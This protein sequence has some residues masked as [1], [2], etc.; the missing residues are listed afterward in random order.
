MIKRLTSKRVKI[1]HSPPTKLDA[2]F[3]M[4]FGVLLAWS[5]TT[6]LVSTTVFAQN[7]G[8]LFF[9]V[10]LS[11]SLLCLI[12][13]HKSFALMGLAPLLVAL[14]FF[15]SGFL[16]TADET[17]F[18]NGFTANIMGAAYFLAGTG[19]LTAAYESIILWATSLL[20]SLFV[21]LFTYR[22]FHFFTLF[23]ISS[24]I[25]GSLLSA[26]VFRFPFSFQLFAFLM[27]VFFLKYLYQQNLKKFAR[28]TTPA[29]KYL[30][31]VPVVIATLFLS[32]LFPTPEPG[33]LDS[34]FQT[35]IVQPFDLVNDFFRGSVMEG[36]FSLQQVGFS[37]TTST[38]GGDV[39]L[40]D[41]LFM[42]IR[43]DAPLPI[44]LT[45]LTRDTYT[46]YSWVNRYDDFVPI[47]FNVTEQNLELFEQAATTY[48][49]HLISRADGILNRRY[50]LLDPDEVDE[51]WLQ[52]AFL[53]NPDLRIFTDP[54]S[55]LHDLWIFSQHS[56]VDDVRFMV[57]GHRLEVN[58]LNARPTSVFHIGIVQGISSTDSD[59]SFHR[60]REGQFVAEERLSRN[61]SYTVDLGIPF[62]WGLP[63]LSYPHAL[64]DLLE[65]IDTF[66]D[67]YGYELTLT[68]FY[69]NGITLTYEELLIN[70]LIPRANEIRAIYTQL[71]VDFPTEITDLAREVTRTATNDYERMQLL[72]QYL[73]ENFSYTL[74]PGPS[75]VDLDFVYHFLFD[76]QE[77]YCV[78]FATAFVTMA[79]SLGIPT[80]YVEGFR[81]STRAGEGSYIDVRNNMAHAWAEVYFEGYGWYRFE[82]T[83]ASSQNISNNPSQNRPTN[84]NDQ[85]T[86]A[87]TTVPRTTAPADDDN[88]QS[89]DANGQ[90]GEPSH[91][92]NQSN[93]QASGFSLFTWILISLLVLGSGYLITRWLLKRRNGLTK[94]EDSNPVLDQFSILLYQF[95]TLK[96]NRQDHETFYQFADRISDDLFIT[97]RNKRDLKTVA[98]VFD[99]ASYSDLPITEKE[100]ELVEHLVKHLD[101]KIKRSRSKWKYLIYR[102]RA[103]LK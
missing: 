17:A 83:P 96:F 18:A 8:L 77:G 68:Q 97:A 49:F 67:V 43:T 12:F 50:I 45:G 7:Y 22:R 85:Q 33:F 99:K 87:P 80:R 62:G 76:I 75:P 89:T 31:P 51:P 56:F 72:E 39:T 92:Q 41:G 55:D 44:Y 79:R 74:T 42:Q 58:V 24:V 36:E 14:L 95:K 13:T 2:I 27:L 30:L 64:S 90:P 71:P 52:E 88:D 10:T 102:W 11:T 94:K 48:Y 40:S 32:N 91:N 82:P 93:N 28:E 81:L 70:Y 38:L 46:G 98:D 34:A 25:F 47:D 65:I 78:H 23:A 35:T 69:H 21:V 54:T 3:V 103:R 84:N 9:Q 20:F 86:E 29:F 6:G 60:L 59:S 1:K 63:Y 53:H 5:L 73:R 61:S 15:A 26:R 101:L 37:D 19:P 4:T 100:H 16:P 57:E 66:R